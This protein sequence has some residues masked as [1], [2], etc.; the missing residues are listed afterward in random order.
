MDLLVLAL[1]TLVITLIYLG[2]RFYR[3]N[4]ERRQRLIRERVAYLLWVLADRD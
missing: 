3:E 4:Q 2:W 1:A